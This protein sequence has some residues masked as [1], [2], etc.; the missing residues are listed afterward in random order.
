MTFSE[1]MKF[2]RNKNPGN[3]LRKINR[4]PVGIAILL[5][6]LFAL[7][8][9]LT[10][11]WY[12]LPWIDEICFTDTPVNVVLQKEWVSTVWKYSYNPLHAFLLI[13]WLYLFGISHLA[14]TSINVVFSF[15]L[16]ILLSS[17]LY[18]KKIIVSFWAMMLYTFVF[19]NA[20]NFSWNFRCGRVDPLIMIFTF[21]VVKE[22]F[23]F[24]KYAA[25]THLM[26]FRYFIYS[27]LLFL[28][29]VPS[30]PV[31]G[32][33]I[34]LLYIVQAEHRKI[35]LKLGT[36]SLIAFALGFGLICVFYG[37]NHNI[38]NY[39]YS[40]TYYNTNTNLDIVDSKTH[41]FRILNSYLIN[42]EALILGISNLLIFLHVFRSGRN[43]EKFTADNHNLPVFLLLI[44]SVPVIMTLAGRYQIYYSWMFF[45]PVLILSLYFF[46]HLKSRLIRTSLI[47][48]YVY[49]IAAGLPK[50]LLET[51]RQAMEKM[52]E[53]FSRQSIEQDTYVISDFLPYYQ[54]RQKTKN[55]YIPVMYN[56][57]IPDSIE[58]VFIAPQSYGTEALTNYLAIEKKKGRNIIAVDSIDSPKI[59]A[60]QVIRNN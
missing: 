14:V 2:W 15:I 54:L 55:L 50:S 57:L 46:G 60:Y 30:L 11:N 23:E 18:K 49:C 37:I 29:G 45:L 40:F 21:L 26:F 25:A 34:V 38:K 47:M 48:V 13:P 41:I 56:P 24:K 59:V 12:P 9:I 53:F 28:S 22:C 10:L 52:D 4:N 44:M 32:S 43:S 5:A 42:R 39:L 36:I 1:N 35:I 58:Y 19:W 33:M 17:Y 7:L 8:N 20:S 31:V 16:F 3:N 51:D 6:L 27:L